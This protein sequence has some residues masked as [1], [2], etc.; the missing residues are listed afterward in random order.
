MIRKYLMVSVVTFLC[1][2]FIDCVTIPSWAQE[3]DK[4][5]ANFDYTP[6]SQGTS[7]SAGV[8]F[9]L[10]KAAY[11]GD[12]RLPWITFP[13]FANLDT[14]IG[15]DL[16]ELLTAKGFSVRGPLDSYDLIPYSEKKDIDLL[17]VP[18]MELLITLK[19]S[20][21]EKEPSWGSGPPFFNLTGNADVSGKLNL[22]LREIVTRELM[23]TKNIPF[24]Y[25]FP[26][27]VR[28]S[29]YIDESHYYVEGSRI[30]FNYALIMDDV[31][32][33]M[34]KEYPNLMATV[35][36]LLDPEEMR[37]IK[38]QAQELKSKKGY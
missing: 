16:P 12:P 21:A 20:K 11:K 32:K 8:T 18:T 14:A 5:V 31:A 1:V 2:I 23:W 9:T 10:I 28:I 19:D 3:N 38:K 33:G 35:Y 17:L 24:T 26:Y 27:S 34:E 22:E 30:P 15:Q 4:Y 37:I 6:A 13:Q 29:G 36:K 7:G 25:T